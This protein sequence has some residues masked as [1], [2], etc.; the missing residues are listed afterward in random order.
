MG[1]RDELANL[2]QVMDQIGGVVPLEGKP[3]LILSR[4][5]RK[6]KSS[7]DVLWAHAQRD[8][9]QRYPGSEHLTAPGSSH[10]IHGDQHS[11]FL[12]PVQAFLR[13]TH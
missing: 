1:G 6:I 5:N 10:N 13:R 11:W 7:F 4:S 12:A 2:D 8:L 9:A 3:V